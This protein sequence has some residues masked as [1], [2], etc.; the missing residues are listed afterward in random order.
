MPEQA[1]LVAALTAVSDSQ[2]VNLLEIASAAGDG[3]TVD[4]ERVTGQV[5]FPRTW[6]R[7]HGL[8][9][10]WCTVIKVVG[11]SM[12]PTLPHG[13]AILV[14]RA[15]TRRRVGRIFVLRTKDGLIVKRLDRRTGGWWLVSDHPQ[16][17][18]VPYPNDAQ[19]VGEVK[20]VARTL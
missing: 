13:C 14:N 7:E 10:H 6:M 8:A 12:D 20:W 9:A 3:A 18:T 11:E 15:R 19:I 2:Q 4:S 5:A 17:K 16:W 1:T